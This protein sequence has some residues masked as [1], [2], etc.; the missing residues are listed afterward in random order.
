MDINDKKLT[1]A[2]RIVYFFSNLKPGSWQKYTVW[3]LI[4]ASCLLLV[5]FAVLFII[6]LCYLLVLIDTL[7]YYKS[8]EFQTI[9]SKLRKKIIEYN[10]FDSFMDETRQYIRSKQLELTSSNIRRSTLTVY[11][12]SR[13]DPYKYIVKYFFN[14]KHID[15]ASLQIIE[16]ILQKYSTI[17]QTHSI[18]ESE[19]NDLMKYIAKHMYIGA[20]IFQS[21][22][23]KRLGSRKLPKFVRDYY[24]GYSFVYTSPSD[25]NV[26]RNNILLD[27]PRLQDFA[28]YL[29]QQ[30]KYRKSAKFQRQL[31]TKAL[32]QM[33]LQRDDYTC[34]NCGVSSKTEKH[35][36]LE[37]DHIMPIA[38]GGITTESNLQ[39]L[40][41]K[42]NR[43]KGAKIIPAEPNTALA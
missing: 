12:N 38:K 21:M 37:I 27:E 6:G 10:E 1:P 26:R 22:T 16:Q 20:Y 7:R 13:N 4:S 39:T 15:E 29:N 32:R 23:M 17:E 30:I 35:L 5:G 3:I 40:C 42:C 31:M 9:K 24:I 34:K 18:L 11:N 19:Y 8:P 14:N 25:R 41:W 43:S 36:L 33:I 28:E 2:E